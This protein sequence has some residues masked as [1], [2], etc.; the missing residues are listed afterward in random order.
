[1]SA[2]D[3]KHKM[4]AQES[5]T[6]IDVREPW[7]HEAAKINGARL[8]PLGE[9]ETRLAEIPREERLS[10]IAIAAFAASREHNC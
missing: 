7:E 1:M 10:C 5:L 4:D 8:I 3:L 6:L 9:L 2:P